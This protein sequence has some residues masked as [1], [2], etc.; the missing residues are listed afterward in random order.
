MTFEIKVSFTLV[1]TYFTRLGLDFEI[2]VYDRTEFT[3]YRTFGLVL[4]FGS[5]FLGNTE[6]NFSDQ[7]RG[8]RANLRI[9]TFYLINFKVATA[10]RG[11]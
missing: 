11:L 4:V 5:V 7:I 6:P 8:P 1:L 9:H 10:H 3:E 2:P